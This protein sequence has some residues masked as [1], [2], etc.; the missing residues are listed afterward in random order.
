MTFVRSSSTVRPKPSHA[1][2]APSGLLGENNAGAGSGNAIHASRA[3]EAAIEV[4]R[5]DRLEISV[6]AL[7][8]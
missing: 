6:V 4:E 2:Q 1:G 5:R 3:I 7:D 8:S